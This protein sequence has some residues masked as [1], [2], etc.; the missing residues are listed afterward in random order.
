MEYNAAQL[1]RLLGGTVEGDEAAKVTRFARIEHGRPGDLCFYANPRYERYVY[2]TD[3]SILLVNSDFVPAR[4]VSAT[5]VRVQDAYSAVSLL[6]KQQAAQK[7]RKGRH[8]A[9][10]ARCR[11][12]ARLGKGVWLGDFAYV[13]RRSR[14][15]D[16]T[17]ISEH[18]F[19]GDD[20][21]IGR[22]CLFHPGVRILDGTVI[23]DRVILPW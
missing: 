18:V 1:A 14:I 20:V 17:V 15:G 21:T 12:S 23:G 2:T 9:L 3:A 8:R 4:S 19:I 16:G 11:L 13:G 10:S 7:R 6:L 5:L 22:D